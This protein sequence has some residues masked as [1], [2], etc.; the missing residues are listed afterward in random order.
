MSKY[1]TGMPT[2]RKEGKA[3]QRK[4]KSKHNSTQHAM[5]KIGDPQD[6]EDQGQTDGY[7]RQRRAHSQT[8]DD[9]LYCQH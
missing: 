3:E 2:S 8:V 7:Q 9:N 6:A 1:D 5:R 4:T